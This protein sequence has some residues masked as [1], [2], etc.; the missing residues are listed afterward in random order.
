MDLRAFSSQ[1][2]DIIVSQEEGIEW[3]AT[4]VG[5]PK[6]ELRHQFWDIMRF[7]RTMWEGPWICAGDFNEALHNDEHLGA[8]DREENQMEFF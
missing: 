1:L 3:R 6:K 4:L 8:R 5:E 7:F 2:I